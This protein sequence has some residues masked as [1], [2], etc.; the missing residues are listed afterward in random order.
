MRMA[1]ISSSLAPRSCRMLATVSPFLAA[2]IFSLSGLPPVA[3]GADFAS[4]V[5]FSG[6]MRGSKP[7]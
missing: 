1:P 3:C 2:T 6:T 5:M 7:E 4:S